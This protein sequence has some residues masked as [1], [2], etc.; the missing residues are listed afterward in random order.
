VHSI[1]IRFW[2]NSA[3]GIGFSLDGCQRADTDS[4]IQTDSSGLKLSRV[5]SGEQTPHTLGFGDRFSQSSCPGDSGDG[6]VIYKKG[7]IMKSL[8]CFLV[9]HDWLYWRY[10]S[11][12][13][14]CKRCGQWQRL[15]IEKPI[16]LA[17]FSN[18][19]KPRKWE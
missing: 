13:R 7:G 3:L 17:T 8:I 5:G 10:D 11:N 9:R 1:R 15:E 18:C 2:R 19:E 4:S 14:F 16:G 12:Y 6:W